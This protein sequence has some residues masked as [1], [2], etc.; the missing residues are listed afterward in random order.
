MGY[1]RGRL[2]KNEQGIVV[3]IAPGMQTSRV[4]LGYVVSTVDPLPTLGLAKPRTILFVA[5]GI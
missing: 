5:G 1:N 3:P 2:G 4:G